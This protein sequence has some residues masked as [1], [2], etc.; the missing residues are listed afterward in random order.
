MRWSNHK[1]LVN[2]SLGVTAG[3]FLLL[4]IFGGKVTQLDLVLI[5]LHQLH[6]CRVAVLVR[7]WQVRVSDQTTLARSI[8]TFSFPCWI[9]PSSPTLPSAFVFPS[10]S[11]SISF[12]ST[13]IMSVTKPKSKEPIM[14]LALEVGGQRLLARGVGVDLHVKV[15][16]HLPI[17]LWL[18]LQL[19]LDLLLLLLLQLLL[20]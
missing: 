18:Q 15:E 3:L 9:E 14:H 17:L 12:P 10:I 13:W 8:L 2:G 5:L 11:T 4:D 19:H 6:L 16:V 1:Y 7:S 20:S